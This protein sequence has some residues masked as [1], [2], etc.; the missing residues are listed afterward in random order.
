VVIFAG[1]RGE[2]LVTAQ[3]LM[4]SRLAPNLVIPNGTA[5]E[6]PAGNRACSEE[7]PYEVHCPRPEPD[8]TLGEARMIAALAKDKGWSRVIAVTS[9][10]QLSRARLLLGRCFDGEV[11][12]V[13]AQPE[14]SALAWAQRIGHEWL[15]WSQAMTVKRGC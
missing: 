15:A 7:L 2:R 14:L 6:W 4:A 11:L 12:G 1:G 3:R 8:T 5:P 10:Y 13:R 9:S